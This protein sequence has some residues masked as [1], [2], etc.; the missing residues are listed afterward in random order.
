M[1][2][3]IYID[4]HFIGIRNREIKHIKPHLLIH[5]G[6]YKPNLFIANIE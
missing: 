2:N 5:D 3:K 1:P 6:I 4:L